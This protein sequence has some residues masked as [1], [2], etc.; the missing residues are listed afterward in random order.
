MVDVFPMPPAPIRAIG[1]RH[2]AKQTIFR[3]SSSR[4]NKALGGGGGSSPGTL[5]ANVSRRVFQQLM[6]LTYSE[7]RTQ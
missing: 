1:V 5:D 4:P 7:P 3:I 6:L 2:C